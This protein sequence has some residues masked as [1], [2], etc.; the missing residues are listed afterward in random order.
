MDASPLPDE[1]WRERV[2]R[3]ARLRPRW[4]ALLLALAGCAGAER[5]ITTGSGLVYTVVTRGS[6]PEA[7]AG[8]YVLIHET[9]TFPDGRVLYSTRPG[10]RPLRFLLGAGQVIDGVDEGVTGMR[11]G[12]RRRM[13]VPPALSRRTTYPAG[14]SPEDT[15]FY[16]VELVGI[17]PP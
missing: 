4:A 9:T 2:T 11:V 13:I 14:L 17:D 8:Q 7:R 12:E 6:G 10:E 1:R 5:P 15:L 3:P 16:D